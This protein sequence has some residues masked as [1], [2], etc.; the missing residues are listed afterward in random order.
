MGDLTVQQLLFLFPDAKKSKLN[1]NLLVIQL[2]ESFKLLIDERG[3]QTPY[4]KAAFLSQCAHESGYFTRLVENLNYSASRLMEIWPKR[5]PTLD[6]ANQYAR[7]PEKLANFVYS[8][9][10]GNG[11]PNSGDGWKYRGRGLIQLTGKSNYAKCALDLKTNF[12]NQP[13]LLEKEAGAVQSAMWFWN[14]NHLNNYADKED[15]KGLT[16]AINGGY[17]GLDERIMLYEKAKKIL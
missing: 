8:N 5:F 1:L 9:R 12:V 2:N 15:I 17:H 4:R 14:I 10:L 6:I 13:E 3:F 16:K 7:N 11:P